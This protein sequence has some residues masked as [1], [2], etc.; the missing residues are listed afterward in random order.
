MRTV[1]EN[2]ACP[3][4]APP[5]ATLLQ[6]LREHGAKSFLTSRSYAR[7]AGCIANELIQDVASE[8][9]DAGL[10]SRPEAV[11]EVDPLSGPGPTIVPNDDELRMPDGTNRS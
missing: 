11:S 2:R 8:R 7:F 5:K 10:S 9:S 6:Y 3:I 1:D 4:D